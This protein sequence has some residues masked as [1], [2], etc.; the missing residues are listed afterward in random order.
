MALPTASTPGFVAYPGVVYGPDVACSC[1]SRW[2]YLFRK[3]CVAKGYGD[4]VVWQLTGGNSASAGTHTQGGVYDFGGLNNAQSMLAR[5]AG[6]VDYPRNWTGNRHRHGIIDCPH[7]ERARYQRTA[8][9]VY[10]KN[11]LGYLGLAGPD[12]LPAPSRWRTYAEGIDW[13]KAE[14]SKLNVTT[15][16][17]IDMGTADELS[18]QIKAVA[19]LITRYDRSNQARAN[20]I[21]AAVQADDAEKDAH[22]E[23]LKAILAEQGVEDFWARPILRD[24]KSVP[25]IQE[26]A[27]A[28]T[29]GL[30]VE[31]VLSGLGSKVDALDAAIEANDLDGIRAAV[32]ALRVV[33]EEAHPKAEPAIVPAT[34]YGVDVSGWQTVE[35]VDAVTTDP[36]YGF[37]IVKASQGEQSGNAAHDSQ[38][39]E[40]REAGLCVGHY[41]FAECDQDPIKE[42]DNFLARAKVQPGD[43]VALDAEDWDQKD[44]PERMANTPWTQRVSFVLTWLEEAER[45]LGVLPPLYVN[46]SWIK[47][48]RT[49]ATP[50]QWA[51]LTRF[52]VWMAQWF[53]AGQPVKPGEFDHID[54]KDGTPDGWRVFMH[55]WTNNDNGLDGNY[56]PNPSKWAEFAIK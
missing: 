21:M 18:A 52:E 7:N 34:Q 41:H 32:D 31:K 27:D 42:L 45:R 20:A 43:I 17:D 16:E 30:R 54:G 38:V 4:P 46:W 15:E 22:F 3:L 50:E 9:I 37:V 49:A 40:V 1:L 53:L 13:M 5:E 33:V 55:Q 19:N 44:H 51:R 25:A 23:T 29:I 39:A 48:L 11:G 8:C 36:K 35:H 12:P 14:L 47:G 26:L 24:G 10:R 2:L 56:L 6:A 28:K